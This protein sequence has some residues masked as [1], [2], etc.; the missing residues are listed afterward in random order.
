RSDD[1]HC[2]GL[3]AAHERAEMFLLFARRLQWHIGPSGAQPRTRT[4]VAQR[5]AN[6]KELDPAVPWCGDKLAGQSDP[7]RCRLGD[8][9]RE[10]TQQTRAQAVIYRS[11]IIRIYQAKIPELR[12]LVNVGH[13]GRSELENRLRQRIP[14]AHLCYL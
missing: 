10:I 1:E 5:L 11:P 9:P 14:H 7:V 2:I 8:P 4:T 13:A 6:H 12:S 3:A